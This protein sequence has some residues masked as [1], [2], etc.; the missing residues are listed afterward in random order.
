[1]TKECKI[2]VLLVDNHPLVLDGLRAV[3]ETY[4]DIEIAGAASNARL[5]LDMAQT[6]KPDVV[7][8]DINISSGNCRVRAF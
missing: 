2:R 1:M 8:M 5:A 3:L 4:D 6:A 7:L